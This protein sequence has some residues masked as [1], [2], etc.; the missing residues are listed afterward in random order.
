MTSSSYAHHETRGRDEPPSSSFPSESESSRGF[1]RVRRSEDDAL[2]AAAAATAAVR[3]V[4]GRAAGFAAGVED[5]EHEEQREA[6]RCD[7]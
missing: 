7:V 6:A 2:A 3:A 1:V 5:E 4:V